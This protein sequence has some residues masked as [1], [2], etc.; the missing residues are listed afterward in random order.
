MHFTV[1][2]NCRLAPEREIWELLIQHS[3]HCSIR[4]PALPP[5]R[6]P[7]MQ[8]GQFQTPPSQALTSAQT[9]RVF[10][11]ATDQ[12]GLSEVDPCI[13]VTAAKQSLLFLCVFE[14]NS[15]AQKQPSVHARCWISQP[16]SPTLLVTT[17]PILNRT[18]TRDPSN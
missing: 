18:I 5:P 9:S 1:T 8:P 15:I 17:P 16:A 14:I 4:T 11:E 7:S 12:G 13:F 3:Q 6:L 2:G 10:S